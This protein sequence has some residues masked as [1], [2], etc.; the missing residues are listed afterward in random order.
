MIIINTQ[1]KEFSEIIPTYRDFDYA[2]LVYIKSDEISKYTPIY[3]SFKPQPGYG[4]KRLYVKKG[5]KKFRSLI[6]AC[7]DYN[8]INIFF[9]DKFEERPRGC[10]GIR[11]YWMKLNENLEYEQ[12]ETK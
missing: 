3:V 2:G 9:M 8:N 11:G 6:F 1:K 5:R 12:Y 10:N 7:C 4:R